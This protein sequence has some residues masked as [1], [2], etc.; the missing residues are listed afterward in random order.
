VEAV[1]VLLGDDLFARDG[2]R[3]T[4]GWSGCGDGWDR[5]PRSRTGEW[6]SAGG[7]LPEG[8]P[9]TKPG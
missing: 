7:T 6:S 3:D 8:T 1:L 4:S 5:A 2:H 9:G